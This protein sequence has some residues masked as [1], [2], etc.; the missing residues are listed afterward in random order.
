[1]YQTTF[2]LRGLKFIPTPKR[3]N[4]ELKSNIQ[5]YTLRLRLTEFFQ[6]K[7]ANDSGNLFQN[8]SIF[9]P[10]RNRDRDLDHQIDVL[11]HLNLQKNGGKI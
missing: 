10:H 11:N 7:D 8:Q 6:N 9:T 4:I 5:N 3:K 2:L 1:M